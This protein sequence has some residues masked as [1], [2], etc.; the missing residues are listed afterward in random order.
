MQH[1]LDL[2][3]GVWSQSAPGNSQHFSSSEQR[4]TDHSLLCTL[5]EA[6]KSLILVKAQ[7]KQ[8]GKELVDNVK[9]SEEVSQLGLLVFLPHPAPPL[10]LSLP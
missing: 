5:Q 3:M 7:S 10:G 9:H 1:A 6:H 4:S 2:A 8:C